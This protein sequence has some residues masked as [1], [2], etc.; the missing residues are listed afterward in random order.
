MTP[1]YIASPDADALERIFARD[2]GFFPMGSGDGEA[3][4]REILRLCP[5]M[6]VLDQVLT[7]MDGGDMMRRIREKMIAPPRVLLL[8]RLALPCGEDAA[9]TACDWP[10]S[11][12]ALLAAAAEA[13]ERP[14]PV[15]AEYR[16]AERERL[17]GELLDQLGMPRHLKGYAYLRLAAA[18]G[19]CAPRLMRGGRL[20]PRI[21]EK[22]G[23]TPAAVEKAI[24]TAIE[25]TW[26]RGD[27]SAIQKLFGFSVDA[28][29]GKPTN[30]ECVAMLSEHIR[31]K[32]EKKTE[33]TDQPSDA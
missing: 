6:L 11:P 24:R 5:E 8:R 14:L 2:P 19:A 15:L 3:A 22:Y 13:A 16:A 27:W 33:R 20:N 31:R 29:K 12:E 25:S 23:T 17:A 32:M 21:A 7:G 18:D 1:L 9:D 26:L 30:A 10:C 4:L 28:E